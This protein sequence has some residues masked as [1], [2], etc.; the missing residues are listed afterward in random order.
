MSDPDDIGEP[1]DLFDGVV[2]DREWVLNQGFW[3]DPADR[4]GRLSHTSMWPVELD[5]CPAKGKNRY[6][7]RRRVFQIAERAIATPDDRFSATQF[8]VASIIWGTGTGARNAGFRLRSLHID[9]DAPAKLA[10][11]LQI[12]RTSGAKSAFDAMFAGGTCKVPEIAPAF[13]SKFLYFAGYGAKP[14]L[15]E[16]LII[17]RN[18]VK[19]LRDR[20]SRTWSNAIN[21]AEYGDYRDLAGKWATRHDMTPDVIERRLFEL[22][23][24]SKREGLIHQGDQSLPGSHVRRAVSKAETQ[25]LGSR[26]NSLSEGLV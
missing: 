22:G 8:M 19:A 18:V 11:V 16:P 15:W 13:F 5:D 3:F 24:G 7:D 26:P 2:P 17:D 25:Y 10:K 14:L 6:V 21:A 1:A 12:V 9:P 23:K 20:T 4:K